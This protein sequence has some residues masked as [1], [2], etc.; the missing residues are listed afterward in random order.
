MTPK[1]SLITAVVGSALVLGVPAGWGQS[2]PVVSSYPD[3]VE[4]AV[5]AREQSQRSGI[6]TM[7]DAFERAV[8]AAQRPAVS[9]YVDAHGRSAL[10]ADRTGLSAASQYP[11]AFERALRAES[12]SRVL[13]DSHDR[14]APTQT[15][16]TRVDS[17]RDLEWPQIGVGFGVGILLALG[18]GMAMRLTRIR[19]PA[20]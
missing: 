1:I 15:P 11:D 6:G 2:Q 13:T 14:I 4:R 17:G 18:L 10:G 7:P 3:A 5:F 12:T 16:V 19:Q 9:V 8:L 20:H